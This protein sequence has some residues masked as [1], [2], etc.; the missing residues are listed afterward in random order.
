MKTNN[1]ETNL[2]SNASGSIG[3]TLKYYKN[4]R[5]KLQRKKTISN[6]CIQLDI[7][8]MPLKIINKCLWR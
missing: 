3:T 5:I 6:W 4:L 2:I 8:K 7:Y 1:D